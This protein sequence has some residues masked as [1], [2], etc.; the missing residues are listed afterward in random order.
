MTELSLRSGEGV[1]SLRA[2]GGEGVGAVKTSLP[3]KM[4]ALPPLK[5]TKGDSQ[6]PSAMA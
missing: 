1:A 6:I 3:A 5:T 4:P 2:G